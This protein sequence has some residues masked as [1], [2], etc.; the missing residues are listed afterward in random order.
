VSSIMQ[1]KG[2]G[3][4]ESAQ[5]SVSNI[6]CLQEAVSIA[7]QFANEKLGTNSGDAEITNGL[8]LCTYAN[9]IWA[10]KGLIAAQCSSKVISMPSTFEMGMASKIQAYIKKFPLGKVSAWVN[11]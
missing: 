5:A 7:T 6:S 9:S 2:S 8:V 10:Y 1:G 11:C 4:P 3:K